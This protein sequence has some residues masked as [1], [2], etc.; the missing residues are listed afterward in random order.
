MIPVKVEQVFLSNA[1]F[2][3]ILRND[4]D[5]RALPIFI[6]QPEAEA[7]MLR[8][9]KI[10]VPRPMTHDLLKNLLD[11]LECRLARVEICDLKEGVFFAKLV[12][13]VDG[14]EVG[15]DSRPSDA[16]ALALRADA[17]LFVAESVMAEAGRF[18]ETEAG[19]TGGERKAA[20]AAPER[21]A[22]TARAVS[23]MQSLSND[24]GK[25][26]AEERYEDAARIRDAMKKL[27]EPKA[28]N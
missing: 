16:I 12:L 21:K 23:P 6:G 10:A 9:N 14:R 25:A 28:G 2:V 13:V 1:G 26:I 7:I 22:R 24:L 18:L 4:A 15:V 3:V 8:I 5:P 27:G 19:E 11:Y 17:P 20:H